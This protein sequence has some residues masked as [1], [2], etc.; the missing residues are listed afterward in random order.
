MSK[1]YHNVADANAR[2][3]ELEKQLAEKQ[4]NEKASEEVKIKIGADADP[5]A[6][7]FEGAKQILDEAKVKSIVEEVLK[8]KNFIS[9]EAIEESLE[10]ISALE[11]KVVLL[12]PAVKPVKQVANLPQT[13]GEYE[14]MTLDEL[15]QMQSELPDW[16]E[17]Q[18]FFNRYIA[19]RR[20]E[21]FK[22]IKR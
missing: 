11:Q 9:T 18:E 10:R 5:L 1:I 21:D 19:P 14:N 17:R 6:K 2:I 13:E 22:R 3:H 12:K 8:E 16:R 15:Y 7:M 4:E 20:E